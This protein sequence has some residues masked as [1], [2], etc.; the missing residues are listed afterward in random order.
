MLRSM[1][2]MQDHGEYLLGHTHL[3]SAKLTNPR[4]THANDWVLVGNAFNSAVINF[5]TLTFRGTA[6]VYAFL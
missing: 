3:G 5:L 1:S 2:C 6:A 4:S